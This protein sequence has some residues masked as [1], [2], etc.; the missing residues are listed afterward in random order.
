MVLSSHLLRDIPKLS[1]DEQ[2]FSL[3]AFHGVLVHFASKSVGYCYE[4][5]Q[6]RWALHYAGYQD[7]YNLLYIGV[8]FRTYIAALHFNCNADRKTRIEEDGQD[9]CALKFSRGRKQW[10]VVPVKED[11]KFGMLHLQTACEN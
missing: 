8:D 5:L 7:C 10:T 3:E 2:T 4:G 11:T 1:S 6:A 9:M